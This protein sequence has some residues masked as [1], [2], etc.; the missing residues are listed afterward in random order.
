MVKGFTVREI[1]EILEDNPK[2]TKEGLFD[3]LYNVIYTEKEITLD[4]IVPEAICKNLGRKYG[5]EIKKTKRPKK[6]TPKVEPKPEPKAEPKPVVEDKKEKV[7]EKPKVEAKPEPKKEEPKQKVEV[8]K[9]KPE[10]KKETPKVEP[11]EEF[12]DEDEVELSKVYDGKYD[13]YEVEAKTYTRLKNVKKKRKVTQRQSN[14]SGS[15]KAD[16]NVLIYTP[17]MTV[18]Q[19]ADGLTVSVGEIVKK[20]VILGYMYNATAALDKDLAEL[21]AEDAGYIL[22]EKILEDITKFEEM[23]IEDN[24]EDLEARSPIITIMGHVDH[25][26]TTLLDTIRNTRVTASEAGGIT[27]HIGAY[28]VEKSGRKITFIDTPGH[29]AFT[30]MRARGAQVTDIVVLVVAAD[31][32]IMPQTVEAIDHA[33]A[34]KVPIIV[35]INK[36][37]KP[38]AHPDQVLQELTKYGLVP[39]VW[40]GDTI[41]VPI[42]AL[43]A[44]GIEE[45]LEMILLTADMLELKANPNRL[46]I[47][48]VVEAKLDRGRGPV[49]TL[50]VSN[51]TIKIGDPIVV[52]TTYGR[53]RSMTDEKSKLLTSAGPAKAVEITGLSDVPE[54]GDHFMVF[55]DEKTARLVAEERNIRKTDAELSAGAVS[56]VSAL[57]DDKELN[58]IIKGDVQGSIEALKSSLQKINIDGVKINIIRTGVGS[59]TETDIALASTSNSIIIGFNIRPRANILDYAKEKN[60]EVRL[61]SVIYKLL[62]DIEEAMTGM[63]DPEYEERVIGEAEV[64]NTFKA[65]KIG[66]IAGLYVT[67]GVIN[68]SDSIRLIRDSIVI[69]NGKIGS[70]R[71]FDDDVKEVR[72]GFECGLTIKNFNDIKEGDLV[73]TY[74]MVEVKRNVL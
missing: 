52:G 43:K 24:P 30:E 33:K 71:R 64:R 44:Q 37:D 57:S 11:Q 60:I 19:I 32:G 70:L 14:V 26:K 42:S 53:I 74:R 35:A 23:K 12:E 20:L 7:E 27:Q 22:K 25:G 46:G 21:L 1:L 9:S 56:L 72:E 13:E 4:T 40:G 69:Y 16:E 67:S 61:Y 49:A 62:E 15:K 59:V 18:A 2:V 34:A 45:L 41:C 47:G 17:G 51:G 10:T 36:M 50:L 3:D 55:E 66:T 48:T 28:Q 39:E 6:E 8:P 54:A 38:Q 5:Q 29:A 73:E 65:S 58:L 68:N 31:D 63:L